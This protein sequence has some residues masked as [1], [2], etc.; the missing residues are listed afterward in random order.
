MSRLGPGPGRRLVFCIFIY[1]EYSYIF[2]YIF[3]DVGIF[4][5]IPA[6]LEL[7]VIASSC[8]PDR[9]VMDLLSKVEYAIEN[10]TSLVGLTLN[11]L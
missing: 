7:E 3:I 4:C 5:Y 9:Y 10:Q 8:H 11:K 1:C 2:S 6:Q